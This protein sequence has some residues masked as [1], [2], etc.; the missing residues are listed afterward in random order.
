MDLSLQRKL[1]AEILN[2]GEDRVWIDPTKL[3]EVSKALSRQDIKELINKGIIRKKQP[4]GQSRTW[5]RY[6]HEQKKK[7]R[8]RGKGSRKGKRSARVDEKEEWMK[9]IRA[10]RRLLR[11]LRDEKVIDRHLYRELYR[12]AKGGEFKNKRHL[13]LYL[14][15]KGIIK[16]IGKQ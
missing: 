5:A 7:G 11:K 13:L 6:I 16:E 1:A 12:K 2:V 14:K 10:L 15:E 4:K 8:R 9:R 3:E